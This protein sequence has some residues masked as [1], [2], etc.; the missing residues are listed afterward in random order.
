VANCSECART[1]WSFPVEIGLNPIRSGGHLLLLC[2]IVDIS[3]RKHMERVKD[4]F[5]STVSHELRTPLTS[6]SGSLGLLAGQWTE[7]LPPSAA[8]L[9][10]IAHKNCQ[11]LVR[12]INDI[13]DIEKIESGRVV[14]NCVRIDLLRLAGQAIEDNRG[15][16]EGYGVKI[17]L[18]GNST[19][20]RGQR[21]SRPTRFR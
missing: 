12:L 6:I 5:I 3:Q 13:L 20:G 16:A 11:R 4:E 2:V 1:A 10:T 7:Q 17:R 18:D 15:F 9:L 14:L 8:R 21:R 19:V